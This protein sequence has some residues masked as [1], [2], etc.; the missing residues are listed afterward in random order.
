[1]GHHGSRT[2]AGT[3]SVVSSGADVSE[4][5]S[6][7]IQSMGMERGLVKFFFLRLSGE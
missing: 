4:L 3:R 2:D 5:E 1:M 7:V 6:P